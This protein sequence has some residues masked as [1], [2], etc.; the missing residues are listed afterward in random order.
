MEESF[1]LGAYWQGRAE[2]LENAKEKILKT[3]IGLKAIDGQ[4]SN[5]YEGGRSRKEA[6]KKEMLLNILNIEKLCLKQVRKGELDA[7]GFSKMGFSFGLWTGHKEEEASSV[8]F[9]VGSNSKW[10]TNSCFIK[11]PFSGEAQNRLLQTDKSRSI[12]KLFVDIWNPDYAV[13]T[14]DSIRE[15]L[16]VG[17]KLGWMTYI[18]NL[19]IVPHLSNKVTHEAYSNKSHLFYLNSY[20]SDLIV[21][22][23]PLK[24]VIL[25]QYTI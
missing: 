12:I 5:W 16:D 20:N 17:N 13:L 15:N 19:P 24:R 21:E 2:S 18:K 22:L 14:S 25:E 23:L 1:I 10:L 9:S 6:L 3:L 8:S 7:Q 4:F 11:M